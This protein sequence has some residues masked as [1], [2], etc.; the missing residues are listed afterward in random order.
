MC[1]KPIYG[2]KLGKNPSGKDHIKIYGR[3]DMD[4][5]GLVKRYGKESVVVLPCGH[6]SEC[7]MERAKSWATRG[8]LE[9]DRYMNNSFVTLTYDNKYLPKTGLSK[10]DVQLFMKRLRKH[11][12]EGIRYFFCGEY[13]PKTLRPHYHAIIFNWFPEDAKY[14]CK[15][16]HGGVVYHSKVLNQLWNMGRCEVSDVNFD[17]ICYVARYCV[18]KANPVDLSELGYN[19]E[20]ILMSR[21]PGIGYD[22]FVRNIGKIV[23]Y[24][25][26]FINHKGFKQVKLPRYYDKLLEQFN[27]D[28]LK[29]LK[30]IRRNKGELL[31]SAKNLIA[32]RINHEEYNKNKSISNIKSLD[33]L[34]R[35]AF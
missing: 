29:R 16:T 14:Y 2:V 9:S 8:S 24:D 11:Y 31:E 10:R 19:R 30:E 1:R 32:G 26:I 3:T 22:Y 27:P 13:G 25:R 28:A 7:L 6:C 17:D 5:L 33:K 34:K 21:K 35:E 23:E 12:G 18:K 15:G 4:Y 20:F